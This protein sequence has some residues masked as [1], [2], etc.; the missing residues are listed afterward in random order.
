MPYIN[1]RHENLL[2]L[3]KVAPKKLWRQL[4]TSKTKDN[5]RISSEVW[6]AYLKNIYESTDIFSLEDIDFGVNLFAN[7]KLRTLKDTN[8]KNLKIGGLVFIPHIH[9]HLNLEVKQGFPNP[10]THS[11]IIHIFKSGDKNNPSNYQTI[12][13]RSLLANLYDII[14]GKK[15]DVWLESEH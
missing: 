15:I 14:L 2:H 5:D 4:L 11:N 7:G 10:W 1:K 6:N 3:S 12:M 9:K 13:I 8:E